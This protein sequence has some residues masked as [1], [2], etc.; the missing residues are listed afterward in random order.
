MTT[1]DFPAPDVHTG[2]LAAGDGLFLLPTLHQT[3]EFAVLV[4]RAF[5]L[6]RPA[7]VALELPRTIED[8]FRRAVLRLPFLSVILYPDGEEMVYLPI[9]PHEAMVEA[10]RLA[11]E[12]GRELALVDRD[13]G[14][15]PLTR[16]RAPDPY[17][18]TR[19]GPAPYL[20]AL[21]ESLPPLT[22]DQD[23]LRDRTMAFRLQ[24][25]AK[26]QGP[27]LWVGGAAHARGILA[28]LK[29]PLAEPIGRVRRA[30]V[31]LATLAAESSRE[32]LSEI[33]FVAHAFETARSA[34]GALEFDEHTDSQRVLDRLLHQAGARYEKERRGEIP[35]RAFEQLRRFSRNLALVQGVLTPGFYELIVAARGIVDDDFAWIVFDLCA[36]WPAQDSSRSL[37]EVRLTGDDLFLQNRKVRF[38]RRF[39]SK[40]GTLRRLPVRKRPKRDAS[41][42][43][44]GFGKGICSYPPEDLRIETFGNHLRQKALRSLAEETRRVAPLTTSLLDGLDMKESLRRIHEKRLYVFEER[45]LRGGVG[46]VVVIFDEDDSRY[47]WRTTW[48]GEHGQESDMAFYATPLG[49]RIDGP[50]I[51]RCEYGGFLMTVPPG[52]LSDVFSDP[53]YGGAKDAAEVLLLAALDYALEP[54]VVYVA[55]KPPRTAIRQWAARLGK[56]IV[57]MPLGSLSPVTLKRL[58]QFH[59]LSDRDVRAYAKDFIFP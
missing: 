44:R 10:A 5:H 43:K 57:T 19:I 14:T 22:S 38:Q 50:G 3:L 9:E 6:H 52:R 7:T 37:P 21:L 55:R 23:Q 15:Y 11:L 45:L 27:V 42:D 17:A 34:G 26:T 8:P 28:A 31:R 20:S 40:G 30:G 2:T 36:T 53:D 58:R 16:E 13:D 35:R 1:P 29:E 41:W 59:V 56:K 24:A 25:L 49:E 47:E 33:P 46:S 18:I 48:L 32:V 54:R 12:N 39:P 4:R 51:S